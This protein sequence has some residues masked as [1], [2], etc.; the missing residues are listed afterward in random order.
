MPIRAILAD[1]DGTIIDFDR[2]W[3]PAV[4]SVL[5]DLAAGN[6]ALYRALAAASGLVDGRHFLPG[7]PIIDQPST[8]FAVSW[9]SLLQRPAEPTFFAEID[10]KLCRATTAHLAPIGDPEAVLQ[11]LAARGYP[12]GLIT[13]DAAATARAHAHKLKL[14]PVL[15]FVAGYDSGFGAKPHPGAVLA[16]AAAV[17]VPA[18]DIVVVGDSALDIA[19][20]RNA[21]ARAVAVLTGPNSAG[22]AAAKP[23]AVIV[24]IMEL[25]AW[26]ET[27]S[28]GASHA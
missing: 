12:L 9:A 26:L 19:M 24:S 7:S 14:D 10:R 2:T 13:N 4:H 6:A 22:L 21:G 16:F 5:L 8:V 25:P 20:A 23:D 3:A 28:A 27:A 17:G 11:K 15:A 1:K 18:N